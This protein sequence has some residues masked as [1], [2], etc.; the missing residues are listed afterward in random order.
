MHFCPY[1]RSRFGMM[2]EVVYISLKLYKLLRYIFYFY[3][4]C[5]YCIFCLCLFYFS[6]EMFLLPVRYHWSWCPVSVNIFFAY[7]FAFAMLYSL[8]YRSTYLHILLITLVGQ[9]QHVTCVNKSISP[10]I[11]KQVFICLKWTEIIRNFG[12]KLSSN[13]VCLLDCHKY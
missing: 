13:M 3:F 10:H 12:Q 8:S 1:S 11:S 4:I 2:T 6:T 9:V 7:S 5:L